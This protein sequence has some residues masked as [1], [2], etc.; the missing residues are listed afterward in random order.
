[1]RDAADVFSGTAIVWRFGGGWGG[2]ELWAAFNKRSGIGIGGACDTLRGADGDGGAFASADGKKIDKVAD[3]FCCWNLHG[4]GVFDETAGSGIYFV[5]R[6][7]AGA[8]WMGRSCGTQK[9]AGAAGRVRSGSGDSVCADV[10]VALSRR[11]G[12][13]ILVL[14]GFVCEPVRHFDRNR[15]GAEVSA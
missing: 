9:I 14:D 1:M 6:T 11:R 12:W 4:F 10:C 3:V 8:G 5:W 13:E 2:G 15:A 7:I